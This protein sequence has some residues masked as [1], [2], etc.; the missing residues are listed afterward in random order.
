MNVRM[1]NEMDDLYERIRTLEDRERRSDIK[2][3]CLGY[4]C[5]ASALLILLFSKKDLPN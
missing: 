4:V 1:L 5:M 3:T 2:Q